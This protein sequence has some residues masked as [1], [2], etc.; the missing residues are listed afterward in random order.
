LDKQERQRK[1]AASERQALSYTNRMG[2]T[3]YLHEGR[4]KTGKVRYFVAKS[5]R[6]GALPVMPRGF[7]FSESIN[8]VVSV[9]KI[10]SSSEAI[11]KADVT[12]ARAELARHAHLRRHRIEVVKGE[13]VV[14]EPMPWGPRYEPVM[15][16]VP[17]GPG[18]TYEVHRMTYR[19]D[20]GW[21]YPLAFG[22]LSEL[23]KRFLGH[24]GT[25]EFFELC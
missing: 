13:L 15:K 3:Y 16:F 21:S 19:G 17:L 4:T 6:E 8:G 12:R 7:E 14:F 18:S 22:S 9:R 11:P 5:L 20:G 24:V 2:A 1:S 10:D 23:L 25:D